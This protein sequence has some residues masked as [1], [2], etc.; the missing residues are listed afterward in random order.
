MKEYKLAID[1][2]A[3]FK[4]KNDRCAKQFIKLTLDQFLNRLLDV[5]YKYVRINGQKL[6]DMKIKY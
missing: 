6:E 5:S 3:K 1:I 4:A 2:T